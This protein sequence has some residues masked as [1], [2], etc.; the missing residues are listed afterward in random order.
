MPDA[1]LNS[2]DA[3]NNVLSLGQAMGKPKNTEIT[4]KLCHEINKVINRHVDQGAAELLASGVLFVDE[5]LNVKSI[6]GIDTQSHCL[7]CHEPWHCDHSR[8]GNQITPWHF[9]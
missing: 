6:F 5:V 8:H 9:R 1:H 4:D 3:K 7:F 2:S